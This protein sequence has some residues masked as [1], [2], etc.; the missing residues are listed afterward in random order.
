MEIEKIIQQQFGEIVESGFVEMKI[1]ENLEK[2]IA[3]IINDCLKSY[4]DFGKEVKEK[5]KQSLSIGNMDLK[6]PEYNQLVC[7]WI[8][9]MIN[10]TLISTG[11]KQ[12]EENIKKFFKPLEKSEY[13]ISEIIEKFID[14]LDE[15]D[16]ED[17]TF[18]RNKSDTVDGYIHYYFDKNSNIAQYSCDYQIWINKDGVWNVIIASE[19]AS[20]MKTAVLYGFDSFLF[21]LYVCKVKI[22]DDYEDVVT[23]RDRDD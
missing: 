15:S 8:T 7:N 14:D 23:S 17:I 21:Q 16:C 4:S 13:K 6:L 1:R 22:I 11:K 20:E 3:S 2:T 19:K 18:I 12:I 5:V 9:E 10:T